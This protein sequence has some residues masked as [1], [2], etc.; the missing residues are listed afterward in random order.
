MAWQMW[1]VIEE[2]QGL[3][4]D[5]KWVKA[6]TGKHRFLLEM[7]VRASGVDYSRRWSSDKATLSL[8]ICNIQIR[9]NRGREEI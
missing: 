3:V 2:N 8:S 5:P 6:K 7:G 4:E 1:T 9:G